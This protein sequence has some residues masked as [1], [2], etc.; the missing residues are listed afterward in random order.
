MKYGSK[1]LKAFA[2]INFKSFI[3]GGIN[4]IVTIFYNWI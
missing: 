4:A 1:P 3:V 2:N